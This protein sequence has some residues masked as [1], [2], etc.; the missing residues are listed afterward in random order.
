[1]SEQSTVAPSRAAT[2]L[3]LRGLMYGVAIIAH[4]LHRLLVAKGFQTTDEAIARLDECFA[5]ACQANPNTITLSLL[6]SLQLV[7]SLPSPAGV[8]LSRTAPA[9][10]AD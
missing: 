3:E 10:E 6:R 7:L 8:D 5:Q 1:M 4:D 9:G 2:E